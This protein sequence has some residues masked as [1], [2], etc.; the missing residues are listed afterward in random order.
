MQKTCLVM[1]IVVC[2]VKA[3]INTTALCSPS[4]G[5]TGR[6]TYAVLKRNC[7]SNSDEPYS[8]KFYPLTKD[9][10]YNTSQANHTCGTELSIVFYGTQ[11]CLS[12]IYKEYQWTNSSDIVLTLS[13]C[14][15]KCFNEVFTPKATIT[16][17]ITNF[18]T[19]SHQ[20]VKSDLELIITPN[21]NGVQLAKEPCHPDK[22]KSGPPPYPY[23]VDY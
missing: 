12:F 11:V 1:L 16:E 18:S 4:V 21:H 19:S 20:N 10:L 6:D 13:K 15:R 2:G 22:G 14:E 9:V 8:P 23:N 7:Y 17:R 3:S 5:T